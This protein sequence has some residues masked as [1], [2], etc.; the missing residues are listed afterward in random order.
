VI[1]PI[2]HRQEARVVN[3]IIGAFDSVAAAQESFD[4][5]VAA[6]FMKRGMSV[7]A[8]E[9]VAIEGIPQE[10]TPYYEES[11]RRG[12]ALVA[13]KAD[14]SR[15]AEAEAIM[16]AH[17]AVDIEERVIRWREQGWT[18][19][20][21]STAPRTREEGERERRLFGTHADPLTGAPASPNEED[22]RRDSTLRRS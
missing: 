12:G 1:A 10:H 19:A 8:S 22:N 7:V 15:V 4:A 17:G 21:P 6:G 5:L 11:L 13:M 2:A 14:E 18:G 20:D 16:K 3:T 9:L